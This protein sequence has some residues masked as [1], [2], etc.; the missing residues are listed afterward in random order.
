MKREP[1]YIVK[2]INGQVQDIVNWPADQIYQLIGF[3]NE[4][5]TEANIHIK[6]TEEVKDGRSS[7]FN[8]KTPFL[9]KNKT[10]GGD[11]FKINIVDMIYDFKTDP[12]DIGYSRYIKYYYEL[13]IKKI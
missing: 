13:K 10:L 4:N 6:F 12:E 5:K 9:L 3:I 1:Y 7:K 2:E 8:L 11:D